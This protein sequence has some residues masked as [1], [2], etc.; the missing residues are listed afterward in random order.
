[1]LTD[2]REGATLEPKKLSMS[3]MEAEL[4][5]IIVDLKC[6]SEESRGLPLIE[7]DTK[8]TKKR[9]STRRR[10]GR[11]EKNMSKLLRA[12]RYM[13]SLLSGHHA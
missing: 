3:Y 9:R 2:V 13:K 10:R 6:Q 8:S 1:V 7:E 5:N 12:K 4:K 11:M